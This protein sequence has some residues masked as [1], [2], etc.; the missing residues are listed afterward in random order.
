MLVSS[1]Q[2]TLHDVWKRLKVGAVDHLT[3]KERVLDRLKQV[4]GLHFLDCVALQGPDHQHFVKCLE[5]KP[6]LIVFVD[7]VL[8]V[9]ERELIL[10]HPGCGENF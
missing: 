8:N 2:T 10:G 3:I 7:H 5:F 1:V 6:L 4:F 9:I